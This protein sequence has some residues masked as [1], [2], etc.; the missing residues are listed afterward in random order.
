MRLDLI[1]SMRDIHINSSLNQGLIE[2]NSLGVSNVNMTTM[3]YILGYY[4]IDFLH[5]GVN[6]ILICLFVFDYNINH[7]NTLKIKKELFLFVFLSVFIT[8]IDLDTQI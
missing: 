3:R 5:S 6:S 8:L 4:S 7:Y 2:K 1:L